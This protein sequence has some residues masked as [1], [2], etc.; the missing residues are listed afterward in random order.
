MKIAVIYNSKSGSARSKEEL[1]A[2]FDANDIH[3][4]RYID[5]TKTSKSALKRLPAK[6]KIIA[7]YGGDGTICSVADTVINSSTTLIPLPG[8]TL[9]H[10]TK[11]LGVPQE[12]DE[13]IGRLKHA[14]KKT[15]D[16][17]SV[18]GK[19]FVNN[20]SIGIYPSSLRERSHYEKYLGKWP[21]A[22]VA[23][24]RAFAKF[25]VYEIT[26]NGKIIH[27]PFVFVGNNTYD[28]KNGMTRKSINKGVLSVY[29]IRSNKR[30]TLF[31]LFALA[32]INRL[33]DAEEL[34]YFTT[35]KLHIKS[36]RS[37]LRVATDGEHEV[38]ES[39]LN[40]ELRPGA[41]NIL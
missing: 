40:Y 36:R 38:L 18:N 26:L 39:P 23:S 20:S 1:S 30:R 25:Q 41:L 2:L 15:I 28:S 16:I 27:T 34:Q 17:A 6:H 12:L 29:A 14:K 24:I 5:I 22:I 9:N 3:V 7:A 31:K 33:H 4:E 37:R 13:A 19:T 35:T 21:A 8:G 10:F 32:V 11:D